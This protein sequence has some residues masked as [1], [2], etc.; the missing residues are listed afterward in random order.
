MDRLEGRAATLAAFAVM[1]ALTLLVA[2]ILLGAHVRKRDMIAPDARCRICDGSSR[3][4][5]P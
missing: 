3:K 2:L 4:G 1:V 5:T